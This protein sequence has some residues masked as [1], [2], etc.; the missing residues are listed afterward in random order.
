MSLWGRE[1]C[2][3]AERCVVKHRRMLLVFLSFGY[4]NETNEI[5]SICIVIEGKSLDTISSNWN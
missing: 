4:R 2:I 5:F 1:S 3:N